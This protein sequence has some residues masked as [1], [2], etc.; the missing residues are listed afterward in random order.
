MN[1]LVT[2]S[3]GFIGSNVAQYLKDAGHK[4]I[5]TDFH[6]W[7]ADYRALDLS[8]LTHLKHF[9]DT[10]DVKFDAICHIAGCGD[11][12]VANS[13][14]FLAVTHN[15]SA[16]LKL[17]MMCKEHKV[18][19]LIYV[20]TWEVYGRAGGAAEL[21]EDTVCDPVCHY[22]I[23]KYAAERFA[24]MYD[25]QGLKVIALRIG[26][27]FGPKIRDNSVFRLFWEK[28]RH[29]KPITI[30]GTGEQFRQFTYVADIA[31]AFRL[32]AEADNAH[33][34]YNI[35]S[36]ELITIKRLAEIYAKRYNSTIEY[37][38]ARP[39]D[40]PAKIVNS[41][42]A[43][44]ALGWKPKNMFEDDLNSLLDMW[45]KEIADKLAKRPTL[46]SIKGDSWNSPEKSLSETS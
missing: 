5:T 36:P 19:K 46:L 16:T 26:T 25:S 29:H 41:D 17:A 2:G 45:D 4:V 14:P 7:G 13:K 24:M 32:V 22:S 42:R 21:D 31:E 18:P 35:V 38:E 20:S 23:S 1:I 15:I 33:Q 44:Q 6:L 37:K 12:N 39:N 9:F 34:V 27:A 40:V 8:N 10:V 3:A 28:A 43:K 30:E 11:V